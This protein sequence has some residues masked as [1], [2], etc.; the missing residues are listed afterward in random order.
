MTK[1]TDTL[2]TA[3]EY[4]PELLKARAEEMLKGLNLKIPKLI[5][6]LEKLNAPSKKNREVSDEEFQRMIKLQDTII[7]TQRRMRSVI[8]EWFDAVND[9]EID[10]TPLGRSHKENKSTIPELEK[11]HETESHFRQEASARGGWGERERKEKEVDALARLELLKS[12]LSKK[13]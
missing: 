13:G 5:K 7:P 11:R 4:G 1:K 12:L 2:S 8:H 6:E 9:G 3:A 10:S